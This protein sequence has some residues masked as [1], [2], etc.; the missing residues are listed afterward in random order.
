MKK[1]LKK[2]TAVF[3]SLA[4]FVSMVFI[5]PPARAEGGN[6]M[7]MPQNAIRSEVV[8]TPTESGGV[9]TYNGEVKVSVPLVK[10]MAPMKSS[11][12]ALGKAGAYPHAE[13]LNNIAYI[14]FYVS[15]PNGYLDGISDKEQFLNNIQINNSLSFINAKSTVK[16]IE[17][18]KVFFKIYLNDVNWEGIYNL[19][20]QD[21]KNGGNQTFDIT[22]PYTVTAQNAAEAK[23]DDSEK[24]VADGFFQFYL[25]NLNAILGTNPQKYSINPVEIPFT[26]NFASVY[27]VAPEEP[28]TKPENKEENCENCQKIPFQKGDIKL[29]NNNFINAYGME[30]TGENN[31]SKNSVVLNGSENS[32]KFKV[33]IAGFL[34]NSASTASNDVRKFVKRSIKS[35]ST[36]SEGV[37][38]NHIKIL[39]LL[40][41]GIDL[42][43]VDV[44]VKG[45]SNIVISKNDPNS[46]GNLSVSFD[47]DKSTDVA[48]ITLNNVNFEKN[49]NGV[50]P[51]EFIGEDISL[52]NVY[53]FT[54]NVAVAEDANSSTVKIYKATN[55][56][57][58]IAAVKNTETLVNKSNLDTENEN[59][60]KYPTDKNGITIAGILDASKVK[61]QIGEYSKGKTNFYLRTKFTAK[62]MI[63]SEERAQF[64]FKDLENSNLKEKLKL[65]NLETGK[66][67]ENF[68]IY[69]AAFDENSGILTVEMRYNNSGETLDKLKNNIQDVMPNEMAV[70]VGGIKLKDNAK[71]GIYTILGEMNG[72]F[73]A[74]TNKKDYPIKFFW[75]AVQTKG[76]EDKVLTTFPDQNKDIISF[77]FMKG[78]S[79]V[80]YHNS[81]STRVV[82]KPV[83]NCPINK[84]YGKDRVQTAIKIAEKYYGK[85]NTVILAMKDQFPDSLTATVLSKQLNAPI[86]LT[87]TEKLNESV[88]AE[89]QR[90]GA[91]HVIIVGGPSSVSENVKKEVKERFD[92]NVER[93]SG[94]DRYG[95]SEMVA[96]RVVGLTGKLNKAVVASGE[97]FPDALSVSPY[98]AS[99]GYPILLVRKNQVPVQISRAV[100]DLEIKDTYLIGGNNTIA[101]DTQKNLPKIVER[102]YG[103]TRY[104]TSIAIAKAK[105]ADST[106]AFLTSGEVFSD[107]LVIGPVAGKYQA[108]VLLTPNYTLD[109]LRTYI[110]GSKIKNVTAV[111]GPAHLPASIFYLFDK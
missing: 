79:T 87:E 67:V 15:F 51:S 53:N 34:N 61:N 10:M 104:E 101:A 30:N 22:I 47:M 14:R 32:V 78:N 83:C 19:Y 90:L 64:D 97:V 58:D 38:T 93:I 84:V 56:G 27:G 26:Y 24:I 96:R 109:S 52:K 54:E 33:K 98:A 3:L 59:Y 48:D 68:T 46:N 40:S 35:E 5:V 74:G 18:N 1:I 105:F 42:D 66:N 103:S 11:M 94:T 92:Q 88:A 25:R 71:E 110:D 57:G 21:E 81:T 20:V 4:M 39:F 13:G 50:S 44:N 89:I 99:K 70:V 60:Y 76:K 17:G 62:I 72:Y 100:K 28:S 77:S 63:P 49:D 106:Q 29:L 65:I 41:L 108:P 73:E 55:L 23:K 69:S 91:T 6:N 16:S 43:K 31:S 80:I 86:L 2:M 8:S 9:G 102:M 95:T 12:E 82:E 7:T 111:G 107:A 37:N 36:S 85:A 75:N 45:A